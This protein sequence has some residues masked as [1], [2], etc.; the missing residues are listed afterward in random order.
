MLMGK[1]QAAVRWLSDH[2]SSKILQ[3]SELVTVK[4]HDGSVGSV[5]VLDL[6]KKKHPESQIPPPSALIP[7]SDLPVLED[8]E[9]TGNVILKAASMIQGSARPGGCDSDHWQDV[10]LRYGA[11]STRLCDQVASLARRL[12]DTIVPW[13]DIRAFAASRLI[14][15]DKNPGVRPI[16]VGETLR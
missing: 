7:C 1:V 14:S 8:L 5:S 15:L 2:N 9:V 3:P 6:L 13:N 10:L 16:G 4:H 12:A 11:H